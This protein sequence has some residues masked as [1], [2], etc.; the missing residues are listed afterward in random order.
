ME[1]KR[2]AQD[3]NRDMTRYRVDLSPGGEVMYCSH[4]PAESP[5]HSPSE[6]LTLRTDVTSRLLHE[7]SEESY[8]AL[9]SSDW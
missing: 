1:T 9:F 4:Y 8:P 3:R 6:K 2:K 7:A 5:A